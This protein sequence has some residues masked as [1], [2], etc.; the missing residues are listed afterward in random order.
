MNNKDPGRIYPEHSYFKA[1]LRALGLEGSLRFLLF[2]EICYVASPAA[3]RKA[4]IIIKE[5]TK[6]N[7]GIVWQK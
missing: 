4:V 2:Y 5:M 3:A 7:F 1:I 6:K